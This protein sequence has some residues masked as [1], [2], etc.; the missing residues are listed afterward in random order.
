VD[1]IPYAQVLRL[2]VWGWGY[3]KNEEFWLGVRELKTRTKN[4]LSS[5]I[6]VGRFVKK[7]SA[8]FFK[9]LINRKSYIMLFSMPRI[10]QQSYNFFSSRTPKP[11]L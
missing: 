3:A 1:L 6:K 10:I 4:A 9:V 8:V 2:R 7:L 11:K 5:H